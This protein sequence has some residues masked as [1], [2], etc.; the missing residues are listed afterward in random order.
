MKQRVMRHLSVILA[1]VLAAV[2]AGHAED[3][4]EPYIRSSA[5]A[6]LYSEDHSFFV[7]SELRLPVVK[8]QEM[9]AYFHYRES[10]PFLD[11]GTQAEVLY[12]QY[13]VSVDYR[14][15]PNLRLVSLLGFRGS[16]VEDAPGSWRA[17]VVGIGFGSPLAP[18]GARLQ[19]LA[20]AGTYF[21]RKHL[22]MDWWS[23]LSASYRL[24]D[25]IREEYLGSHYKASLNIFADLETVSDGLDLHG[26]YRLGPSLQLLT[27]NSNRCA[28]HL[29]WYANDGNE[30][31]GTNDSGLMLGLD[32]NSSRNL[33]YTFDA[34]AKREPGWFPLVWG[35]YDIGIGAKQ[36]INRFEINTEIVDF[37]VAK[38]LVTVA[39]TYESRQEHRFR[40]FDNITYSVTLDLQ[41]PLP[42]PSLL[43]PEQPLVLGFG[44]WHRSDHS[45]NPSAER[46]APGSSIKNGS[47]NLLPRLRLQTRG[48]DLPYRP[49]S[50]YRAERTEWLHHFDWRVTAGYN[51]VDDRD[52]GGFAGQF[53]LNWDIATVDG[54]VAYARG[55]ISTGNETPDWLAETG[56][57]RREG[58]LFA[59]WENYGVKDDIARGDVFL[60]GLGV[61]L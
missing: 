33:G 32:I 9:T 14:L 48:W 3:V 53:G 45:L 21:E 28:F 55:I 59:R 30:F 44:F 61:N 25:F 56:F 42:L 49:P 36:Y 38:Q 41:T 19:W 54:H 2:G 10:T 26:L 37:R 58:K 35:A 51:T 57:R 50:I 20:I 17:G 22:A 29:L 11:A 16:E 34:T 52:R 31:F 8:W 4:T 13:D 27:A 46:V 39:A 60:L 5:Y 12:R 15:N 7:E 23:D 43:P 18:T 24:F 40:D 1:T 47:H 6:F